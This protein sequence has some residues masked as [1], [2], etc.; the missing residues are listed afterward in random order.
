MV[1]S[2]SAE[3]ELVHSTAHANSLTGLSL[4]RG[5]SEIVYLL[6]LYVFVKEFNDSGVYLLYLLRNSMVFDVRC[7]FYFVF[8]GIFATVDQKY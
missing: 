2:F 3:A 6:Y 7:Q 8:I 1:I 5:L 4:G